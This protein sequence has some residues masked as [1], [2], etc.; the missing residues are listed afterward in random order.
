MFAIA[1]VFTT[2]G[3][4]AQKL[5]KEL[6]GIYECKPDAKYSDEFNGKRKN[7]SFDT[8]KWHYR[9]STKKGLGQGQEF[10]EEKD[11]KLFC[12]GIKE[13]RKSGA[14]VSNDYFQYVWYA[15]K[16]KTTGIYH[17]KRNAWHPSV[18]GSL[19]DT[20]K[21]KVP[22]T[23]EKG[24]S[25]MEIDIMEFSTWKASGTDWNADA[26]AYIWV[27]SIQKR[28]KVNKLGKKFGWK[29]AMMTDGKKDKYKGKV[30]GSHSF[31]EWQTLGMEYH[32][33][34][35]QLWQIDNGEWVKIGHRVVFTNNDVKPSLRTVPKKAVKPLYWYIGNLFMPQGKTKVTEDQITDCTF[36]VDWFHFY[37]LK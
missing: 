31:D 21:G 13:K 2:I 24:M 5:P 11:G 14:I 3:V 33:E 12:Y 19:D 30:I 26:P 27:D 20:K 25:W 37:K 34:Y 23:Y 10:V 36:L 9:E 29:K 7:N 8:K 1:C 15:V 28:A 16:W 4:N 18:W 17:N 22:G 35:L 6:K 32:P